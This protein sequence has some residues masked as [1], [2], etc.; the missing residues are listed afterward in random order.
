MSSNSPDTT[1]PINAGLVEAAIRRHVDHRRNILIPEATVRW[2][3]GGKRGEYRADFIMISSS[4]YA[5]ELEVKISLGD[6]RKDLS[7]PKWVGM[8]GWIT[9]FVYVVPEQLGIP[10]WVP[11]HAGIWHVKPARVDHFSTQP[12]GYE[13]VIAR[14]PHVL[15]REKIP[16]AVVSTWYRNLYYR[17]WEQRID[18]QRCIPRHIREGVV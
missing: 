5:T 4:D 8:P 18:A 15:G 16:S 12:D 14:A 3:T 1:R 6:W 7:K 9:R 13:I 17:F 11:A 10:E 2:P